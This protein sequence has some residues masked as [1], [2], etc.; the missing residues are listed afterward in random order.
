MDFRETLARLKQNLNILQEREA[1]HGSQPPLELLNQIEDHR[2]A[3]ALTK[4]AIVGEISESDWREALRPLLVAIDGRSSEAATINIGDIANSVLNVEGSVMANIQASGDVVG[5]DKVVHIHSPARPEPPAAAEVAI[6]LHRLIDYFDPEGEYDTAQAT[7]G[8]AKFSPQA[9]ELP[10]KSVE[11]L[12]RLW[13]QTFYVRRPG[14]TSSNHRSLEQAVHMLLT[15]QR[16]EGLI[17]QA[18]A[19]LADAGVGKTPALQYMLVQVAETSL[20]HFETSPAEEA[21]PRPGLIPLLV[22]LGEFRP[23][24]Q[25]LTLVRAAYNRFAAETITLDETEALLTAHPCLLL[26][27]DLDKVAFQIHSD[28][29]KQIHEFMNNHPQ[30]RYLITC[31]RS[32]YHDQL[33]PMDVFV[34]AQLSEEQVQA[35]LG[36]DYDERLLMLAR[37]RSMLQILIKEGAEGDKV[38]SQGRLLQR[39]VW[40]QLRKRTGETNLAVEIVETLLEG[41]AF[42]MHQERVQF[43]GEQQLMTWVTT[44]LTEWHE[45]YTWR[46]VTQLFRE[47]DVMVQDDRRRWRFASRSVQTYF[48]AAALY[49]V[50]A[51]L[52]RLLEHLSDFW[53][54]EPLEIYV[55]LIDE[56]SE[57]LFSLIDHDAAVAAHCLQFVG[58]PVEQRV[59]NAIIDGLVEQ[60]R[61]QRSNGRK[62]LFRLLSKTGYLPP[63]SLLW[64]LFYREQKSLVLSALAQA[65]AD[66][67][68]R[69]SRYNFSAI[70]ETVVTTID[71]KLAGVINLWQEHI[72]T[73]LD[74]IRAA[75]EA[76]LISILTDRRLKKE[77][78]RGVAALALGHIGIDDSR[79]QVRQTLLSELGQPRLKPFLAWCITDA[80]TH[81]KHTD[82]EQAGLDLYHRYRR[83]RSALGQLHCANAVYLL[84]E[85]GGR[86][87]ETVK[88]LFEALEHR[89]PE[90]RGH[91]AQSIGKLGLLAARERLE[92][93]LESSDPQ[94]QEQESWALR[95][96]VE[97]LGKVGTL[98]SIQVLEPYLRY[99]QTRTR[100]RVREAIADIRRRY[101]MV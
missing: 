27:D 67:R 15:W 57:F 5:R 6:Y 70:P 20:P 47:T 62:Q 33:G 21:E 91:A 66:P 88:T 99:E 23:G 78:L 38:W 44:F 53:W 63:E 16:P 50:P 90:V 76:E 36:D 9:A 29:I 12:R 25:M 87:H 83:S 94:H 43:Y 10:T 42:Q 24:Q 77:R 79:R 31:R 96:I 59:I 11:A 4:R 30:V 46:E 60:M 69:R 17:R 84:G 89:Q 35:V 41:L 3:I 22:R 75:I 1:K 14:Q 93:R 80:L 97:A 65:L 40:A 28:G 86:F 68:L 71:P 34:L 100:T 39:M 61:Y 51:H 56:P 48:V 64:Q 32:S 72:L 74:D 73:D 37:N 52:P 85:V 55:G 45:P 82:V 92:M 8:L 81:I 54:R 2:Q 19:L 13:Q 26:L 18:A 7:A 58:Y 101:E 95:R 49:H 98:E